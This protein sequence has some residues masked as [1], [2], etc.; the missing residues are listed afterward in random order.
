MREKFIRWLIKILKVKG[1]HIH[2]DPV[3]KE[4][5]NGRENEGGIDPQ[6]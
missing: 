2:R 5:A 4:K 6:L 1:I 3:R